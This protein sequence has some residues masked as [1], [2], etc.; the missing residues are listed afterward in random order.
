M[1][2]LT[3]EAAE[4]AS[5]SQH[6]AIQPGPANGAVSVKPATAIIV[7]SNACVSLSGGA[8]AR[9]VASHVTIA[10]EATAMPTATSGRT[11]VI[12]PLTVSQQA[13]ACVSAD[14]V[15]KPAA[16]RTRTD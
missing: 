8:P 9:E 15:A 2:S 6:D 16:K 4:P 14:T 5:S 12:H 1:E 3:S 10:A 11:A 7:K 13:A